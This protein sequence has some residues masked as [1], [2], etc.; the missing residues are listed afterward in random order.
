MKVLVVSNSK[1]KAL[2]FK[3]SGSVIC[4]T[5]ILDED[6]PDVHPKP[7]NLTIMVP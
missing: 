3:T 4:N 7:N 1:L 6:Q 2:L 5:F